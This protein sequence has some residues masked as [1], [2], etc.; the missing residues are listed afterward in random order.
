LHLDVSAGWVSSSSRRLR[1]GVAL[2]LSTGAGN[3]SLSRTLQVL[4]ALLHLTLTHNYTTD[5]RFE[6]QTRADVRVLLLALPLF[7]TRSLFQGQ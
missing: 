1:G 4:V 7:F 5:V 3:L 6:Q 2:L